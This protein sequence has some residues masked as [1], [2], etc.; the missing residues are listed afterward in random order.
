MQDE[1]TRKNHDEHLNFQSAEQILSQRDPENQIDH[2]LSKFHQYPIL[3]K[4]SDPTN[5]YSKY[6][7]RAEGK[8]FNS[9]IIFDSSDRVSQALSKQT[10]ADFTNTG[11]SRR[12]SAFTRTPA[13]N[14]SLSSYQPQR[15]SAK[16]NS[17]GSNTSS[18]QRSQNT[19][20]LQRSQNTSSLQ[21][22][23]NARSENNTSSEKI[24]SQDSNA[25][26]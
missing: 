5:T 18:L 2:A 16:K 15:K 17:N 26:P 23:Q 3:L 6:P 14:S 22:S 7:P 12:S 4:T 9:N 19:S 10:I 1:V 8:N 21:R 24:V 11:E 25:P 20:S 13:Q